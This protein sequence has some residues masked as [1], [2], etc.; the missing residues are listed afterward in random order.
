M[1]FDAEDIKNI[2]HFSEMD[3]IG[4]ASLLFDV[5]SFCTYELH[6]HLLVLL[7]YLLPRLEYLLFLIFV[8]GIYAI[9]AHR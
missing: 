9:H 3:F 6:L 5:C 4:S 2:L 7:I 1:I 8:L